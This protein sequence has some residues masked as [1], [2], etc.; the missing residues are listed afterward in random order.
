MPLLAQTSAQPEKKTDEKA[1]PAPAPNPAALLERDPWGGFL[2][3]IQSYTFLRF[4]LQQTIER[5]RALG[6]HYIELNNRHLA[7]N[8]TDEQI[9]AARRLCLDGLR[10]IYTRTAGNR[11]PPQELATETQRHRD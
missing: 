1:G 10:T 7:L 6:L 4:N 2:V 9:N 11:K 8:A 3:G 5:T